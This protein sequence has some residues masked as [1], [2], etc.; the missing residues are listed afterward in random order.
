MTASAPFP[1]AEQDRARAY[2]RDLEFDYLEWTWGAVRVKTTAAAAGLPG[3]LSRPADRIAVSDYLQTTASV[4]RAEEALLRIYA[5]PSYADKSDAASY[6]RD[7]L[8]EHKSRQDALAPLA[9]AVLQ[10]QVAEVAAK[11]GLGTLGGAVP[12]VLFRS[13]SVPD[14]LIVSPREEIRQDANIS[15]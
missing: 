3:Y 11:L 13:T 7:R 12:A 10:H 8:R 9:E 6:V 2:T 15:I 1:V 14:A 5:D 4:L